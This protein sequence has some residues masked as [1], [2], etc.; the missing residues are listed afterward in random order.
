MFWRNVLPPSSG[1]KH[2]APNKQLTL[3]AAYL[4]FISEDGES[5]FLQNVRNYVADCVAS[6]SFMNLAMRT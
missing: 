5:T 2:K 1:L 6:S 4:F 3:L